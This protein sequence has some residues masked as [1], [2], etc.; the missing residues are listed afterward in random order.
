MSMMPLYEKPMS[1][2]Q[3][4]ANALRAIGGDTFENRKY[5]DDVRR[6]IIR[7]GIRA[8]TNKSLADGFEAKKRHAMRLSGNGRV[9]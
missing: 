7:M 3:Q 9:P 1:V 6:D 5:L 2:S 8:Y 4:R